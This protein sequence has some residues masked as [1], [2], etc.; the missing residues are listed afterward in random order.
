MWQYYYLMPKSVFTLSVCALPV[1]TIA[2][3]VL[4][5]AWYRVLKT[6]KH[7]TVRTVLPVL[8]T[9]L[10]VHAV[11]LLALAYIN[12]E[13][14]LPFDVP[15]YRE[16]F[17][18][19]YAWVASLIISGQAGVYYVTAL[20][21]GK[22]PIPVG[23]KSLFNYTTARLRSWA[24]IMLSII[25]A[26]YT[27]FRIGFDATTVR[28]DERDFPLLSPGNPIERYTIAIY[29]DI[30]FDEFTGLQRA[31]EAQAFPQS[32]QPELTL[33][34]GDYV[35]VD[36]AHL[37]VAEQFLS[38]LD[39][40]DGHYAVL[41]DHDFWTGYSK[42]VKG[43]ALAGVHLGQDTL[44]YL[45]IGTDTLNL[46]AITSCM[47]ARISDRRLDSILSL[48]RKNGP[49]LLLVHDAKEGIVDAAVA[50]NIDLV[51]AGHTHGSQIAIDYFGYNLTSLLMDSQYISGFYTKGN[52]S[53]YICNG[54]GMSVAPIRYNA[55]PSVGLLSFV[56][57]SPV[58]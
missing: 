41:G 47:P 22:L 19:T 40:P 6:R 51:V 43:L 11:P 42:A 18:I 26:S 23:R 12:G 5:R 34:A 33:F 2:V 24:L 13:Y 45:P 56:R 44:Y 57:K 28:F 27:T 21:I 32:V 1:Y 39:P 29:A 14:H 52:T 8:I 38:T 37:S 16:T 3:V 48:P 9:L 55:T 30:Q 36:A 15:L 17:F 54:I 4:A 10:T 46:Y 20:I 7:R 49:S 58:K 50:H 53:V 31:T 35:N 25:V